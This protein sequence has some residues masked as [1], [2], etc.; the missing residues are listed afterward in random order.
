M[1]SSPRLSHE[2]LPAATPRSRKAFRFCTVLPAFVALALGAATAAAPLGTPTRAQAQERPLAERPLPTIRVQGEGSVAVAPDMALVNLT[3]LRE[4]K[5]ARAALDANNQAMADVL[6]AMKAEGIADKDLQTGGFSVQPSYTQPPRK[7]DGSSEAPRIV[8]YSVSNTLSVRLRDLARIGAVLD[9]AVTL[10]VNSGGDIT[11]AN[12]EPGPIVERA[13]AAAMK[14]A[15]G[16]AKTLAEAAGVGLGPILEISENYVSPR[17]APMA[18][19]KMMLEMAADAVPV[20]TGESSYSVTVNVAWE[21]K[22]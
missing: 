15:I 5:T 14:D 12:A 2:A 10:G 17:P 3:V 8:G 7:S 22:Q 13:R 9:R 4:A 6:A 21:V 18:R 11:F 16:R 19:D 1:K 20:A